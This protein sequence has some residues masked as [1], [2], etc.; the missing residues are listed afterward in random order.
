ML[1]AVNLCI[2]DKCLVF[3]A[4]SVLCSDP[5]YVA[6][7]PF[8]IVVLV[9]IMCVP[10]GF[11]IFMRQKRIQLLQLTTTT[12]D[13]GVTLSKTDQ[14]REPRSVEE[15]IADVE[16]KVDEAF[17]EATQSRMHLLSGA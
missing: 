2:T 15:R 17:S 3:F 7:K 14:I 9:L 10:V 5:V 13:V 6:G 11:F 16:R 1:V 4:P 12:S 8:V